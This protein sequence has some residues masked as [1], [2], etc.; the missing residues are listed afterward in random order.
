MAKRKYNPSPRQAVALY[1]FLKD[2]K[3]QVGVELGVF[4]GETFFYLLDNMPQLHLIGI[5][6]WKPIEWGDTKDDGYRSYDDFPLE[7]Y[8]TDVIKKSKN[9]G[10]RASILRMDTVEASSYVEDNSIDFVFIDADHTYEGVRRDIQAWMP[11]IKE[12]GFICGHDIHIEGVERAVQEELL[13]YIEL[14]NFVWV[15]KC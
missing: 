1:G 12:S 13:G 11:K 4:L 6:L 5:D 9:Y 2:Y 3:P 15:K 8:Y 14:D 7:N 10:K